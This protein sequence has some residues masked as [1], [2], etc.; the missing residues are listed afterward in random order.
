M[1]RVLKQA[2]WRVEGREGAATVLG[3]NPSTLRSRM[4]KLGIRR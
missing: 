2:K 3:L 4:N 1:L